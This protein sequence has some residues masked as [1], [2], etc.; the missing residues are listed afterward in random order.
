M[1]DRRTKL[2]V[3]R[4]IRKSKRQVED[5]GI[6]AEEHLERHF[7][8][9]LHR[10]LQVR[11]FV[12][13]WLL[14]L[15]LLMG[16]TVVQLRALSTHYLT[17]VPAP[18]GVYTEGII[19]SFTNANP[20]FAVSGLDGAVSQLVFSSLLKYDSDGKLEGDLAESWNVDETGKVYTVKLRSGVTWHDG[21]PLTAEDVVFTYHTIQNPD[22]QSPL[23]NSWRDVKVAAKDGSHLTFTLPN[24]LASFPHSLTNGIVPRHV[25]A[26]IPADQLRA[27]R[28]NT[29]EPIGSGPFM[30]ETVEVSGETPE[31][32]QERIALRG[33]ADYHLGATQIQRFIIKTFRSE[34]VMIDSF[35]NKDL[36][37][38]SGL[39]TVPDTLADDADVTA[40][41]MPL[42][43]SVMVFFKTTEGVLAD[44]TVRQALVRAA[45]TG[46]I[47]DAL[48]YTT[49]KSDSPLLKGQLGY[50]ASLTQL[51]FDQQAANR[52]LDEAGWVR[53][54]DGVR[55][56]DGRQLSF[57]LKAPNSSEFTTVTKLLKDMWREIGVRVEVDQ[58]S[59]SD[60]QSLLSLH[61]YEAV[62]YSISIG[63]DPDVFAFWH[64]SQADVRSNN[65]L[66]FS[67]Y[68]SAAADQALEGGRTRTESELRA[69]KY[70]PFLKAW[71]EDAPALALYQPHYLYVVRGRLQGL[72]TSAMNSPL[73][74]YA[75]VHNWTIRSEKVY[76]R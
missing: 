69:V 19:G 71:R 21:T 22:A 51:S 23:F 8:R 42:N 60:L 30:W 47:V 18:G 10:L 67:E 74:R 41:S 7:I 66:N 3:R 37:A 4:S 48:P 64:S 29:A 75:N 40:H 31:T 2:R 59:D 33:N 52:L 49:T 25:L 57:T 20:L 61:Q 17:P 13:G 6:Q 68:N 58:P 5:I 14:L 9:R 35:K 72:E 50:D 45:N 15:T 12:V 70:Q 63:N 55:Q 38:M 54:E 62:I 1:I 24:T 56:K 36:N 65:R 28:F 53:G 26:R 46:K 73:D 34:T 11:R 27:D 43:G 39:S 76:R 32:R 44:K 16:V